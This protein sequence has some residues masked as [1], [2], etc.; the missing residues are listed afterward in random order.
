MFFPFSNRLGCAGSILLSLAVTAVLLLIGAQNVI[1]LDPRPRN[2]LEHPALVY[3]RAPDPGASGGANV[4]D[5]ATA[6][7]EDAEPVAPSRPWRVV[8][9]LGSLIALG[10]L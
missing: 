9:L 5:T 6:P 2:S 7:L 10:P 8:L 1:L 4:T 3:I